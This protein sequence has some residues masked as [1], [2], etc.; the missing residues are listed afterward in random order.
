MKII[1]AH[2]H[3]FPTKI[4]FKASE[5]IGNFYGIPMHSDASPESLLRLQAEL[6][7]ER[8]LVCS[9]A[10]SPAQVETI[11]DFIAAYGKGSSNWNVDAYVVSDFDNTTSIFDI[12]NQCN[13]YQLQTM[14]FALDPSALRTALASG[15]DVNAH[16]NSLWLDDIE[17]SYRYL[18]EQYGPFSPAGLD[19]QARERGALIGGDAPRDSQNDMLAFQHDAWLLMLFFLV[20]DI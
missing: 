11:N 20:L 4:A 2:T 19:E 7:S 14:A 5:S 6:G 9:A 1:D 15:I 12:A 3:I 10:L 8:C 17:R 18:W 13:T 16:D